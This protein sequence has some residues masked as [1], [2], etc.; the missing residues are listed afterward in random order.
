MTEAEIDRQVEKVLRALHEHAH[1]TEPWTKNIEFPH[2][3]YRNPPD[4]VTH[5][6]HTVNAG[7]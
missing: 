1:S 7:K 5:A 3:R 2:H 6:K 4:Q